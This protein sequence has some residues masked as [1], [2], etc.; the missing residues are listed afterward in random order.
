MSNR[1]EVAAKV[2]ELSTTLNV[3]VEDIEVTIKDGFTTQTISG[4]DVKQFLTEGEDTQSPE[5]TEDDPEGVDEDED[6]PEGADEDEMTAPTENLVEDEFDTEGV[7]AQLYELD[8][9]S[10]LKP[11]ASSELDEWPESSTQDD[12]V[13]ALIEDGYTIE[14][15]DEQS[16]TDEEN[17]EQSTTEEQ[18]TT[19]DVTE[20]DLIEMGVKEDHLEKV[21]ELRS[22]NGVCQKEDCP[23]GANDGSDFC[24]SHSSSSKS[25]TSNESS[26]K[27]NAEKVGQ[28]KDLFDLNQ[29][30]ADAVVFQVS[31][32]NYDSYSEAVENHL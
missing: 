30:E 13:E 20:G 22:K 3:D 14:D 10:E 4:A 1:T 11:L 7:E 24:A 16:T 12:L 32:G 25:S 27:T 23:Y 17:D 26:K 31:E 9:N 2:E 29:L 21:M 19:D 28:V 8:Y 5:E 18:S 6:S 15:S